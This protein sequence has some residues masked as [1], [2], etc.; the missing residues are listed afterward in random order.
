MTGLFVPCHPFAPVSETGGGL[1]WY[2]SGK[3]KAREQINRFWVTG[4]GL[5]CARR[6]ATL[7]GSSRGYEPL[8]L[9]RDHM[10]FLEALDSYWTTPESGI[11]VVQ[12][13]GIE[14]EDLLLLC[15]RLRW[16]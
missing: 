14:K 11:T 1:I 2:K 12:I 15:L 4:G 6:D 8:L 16:L 5:L 3:R 10:F 13:N 9:A 7:R